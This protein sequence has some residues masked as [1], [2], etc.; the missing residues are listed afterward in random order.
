MTRRALLLV[1]LLALAG[2]PKLGALGD[3]LD[4][5]KPS[6][7]FQKMR[8]DAVNFEGAD[9]TFVFKVTNPNPLDVNFSSFDYDLDLAGKSFISGVQPKGLKLEAEGDSK[10]KVPVTVLFRDLFELAQD[11]QGQ[12]AVPYKIAGALGFNTPLGE[13]KI[14]V[15]HAGDFPVLK[16]PKVKFGAFRVESIQLAQNRAALALDLELSHEQG[17]NLGFKDFNYNINFDGR[18]V[19]TGLVPALATVGAGASKTVTLPIELNLLELGSSLV[20]A[21][22]DRSNIQVGLNAA[23]NVDTPYGLVP[24]EISK[25]K[26][27]NLQ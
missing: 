5:Y 26:S 15:E 13:L 12:D 23:L 3:A 2:C 27:L 6:V 1:P 20:S 8:T 18:E 10:L 4:K 9:V 25:A 19:A 22:K 14:P 11:I 16:V 24:W 21:I 17:S 7:E